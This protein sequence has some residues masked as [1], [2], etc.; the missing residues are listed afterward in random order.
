MNRALLEEV[1]DTLAEVERMTALVALLNVM[2]EAYQ[3]H[4]RDCDARHPG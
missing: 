1:V 2:V 3:Q 4:P